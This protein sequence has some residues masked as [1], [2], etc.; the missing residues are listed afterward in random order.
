MSTCS[1]YIFGSANA[2]LT[3]QIEG[4]AGRINELDAKVT[5]LQDDVASLKGAQA[6][7]MEILID[8]QR[9]VS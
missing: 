7:M 5:T 1:A 3:N 8:I 6:Q 4:L 2:G 9:R